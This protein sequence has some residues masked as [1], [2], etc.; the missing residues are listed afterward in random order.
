MGLLNTKDETKIKGVG[1][2]PMK[3]KIP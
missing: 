1:V 3:L 2:H